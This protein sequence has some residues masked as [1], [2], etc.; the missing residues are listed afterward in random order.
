M[1]PQKQLVPHAAEWVQVLSVLPGQVL[2]GKHVLFRHRVPFGQQ[3]IGSVQ[4]RLLLQRATISCDSEMIDAPAKKVPI[5]S[6]SSP[7][8]ERAA[9]IRER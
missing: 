9:S 6:R 5:K 1:M 2:R 8:R 3:P 7:R 4:R